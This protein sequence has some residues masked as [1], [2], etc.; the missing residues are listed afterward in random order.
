[1]TFAPRMSSRLP[2]A[3]AGEGGEEE[4]PKT[5]TAENLPSRTKHFLRY[6]LNKGQQR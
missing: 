5:K 3:P 6:A 2:A 4:G 1:M